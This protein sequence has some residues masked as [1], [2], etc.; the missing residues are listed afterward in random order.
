MLSL[1]ILVM[2]Q[3]FR[4][5]TRCIRVDLCPN[6]DFAPLELELRTLIHSTSL[7]RYIFGGETSN[8]ANYLDYFLYTRQ[9]SNRVIGCAP[10]LKNS[11]VD[12]NFPV[13]DQAPTL[14]QAN[15]KLVNSTNHYGKT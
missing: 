11:D 12:S 4:G 9:T 2:V 1:P 10:K 5:S 6:S 13:P 15:T 8:L 7:S 14:T 3:F